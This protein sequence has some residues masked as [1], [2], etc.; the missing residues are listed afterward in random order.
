MKP[1]KIKICVYDPVDKNTF[2]GYKHNKKLLIINLSFGIPIALV[3]LFMVIYVPIKVSQ[4]RKY[5]IEHP[6]D[7]S[8]VEEQL[9]SVFLT[10]GVI[11]LDAKHDE[12]VALYDVKANGFYYRV[13]YKLDCAKWKYHNYIQISGE[14][15]K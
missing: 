2:I 6:L 15:Y 9:E 8:V 10:N 14:Q 7:S 4:N 5:A 1:K 11:V 13:I 3:F 12:E